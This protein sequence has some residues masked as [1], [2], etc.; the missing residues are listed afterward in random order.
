MSF[1]RFVLIR[2]Y[3]KKISLLQEKQFRRY[4]KLMKT[5]IAVL[6]ALLAAPGLSAAEKPWQNGRLTV[7]GQYLVHENG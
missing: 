4:M 7:K 6:L 5:V 1:V 2:S 3:K